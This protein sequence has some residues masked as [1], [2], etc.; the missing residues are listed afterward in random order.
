MAAE[1]TTSP[2]TAERAPEVAAPDAAADQIT[3][4]APED[5]WVVLIDSGWEPEDEQDQP[6]ES[7][8]VG[9]WYVEPD[10]STGTFRSNPSYLP[11][12]PDSPTDP[13]DASLRL[14]MRGQLPVEELL[15]TLPGSL[16][17]IGLD[18]QDVPIITRAPDGSPSVLV[19]SALAHAHRL[20]VPSWREVTAEGLADSLPE[21][22]VDVLLN[23]GAPASTRIGA[24]EFCAAVRRPVP[25]ERPATAAEPPER[26]A[27]P[28]TVA[29]LAG[30]AGRVV[31]EPVPATG[32][33]V[34]TVEDFAGQLRFGAAPS[35]GLHG[36]ADGEAAW[37]PA[38]PPA[39]DPENGSGGRARGDS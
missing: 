31:D 26:T 7:A 10:G 15:A 11:S 33:R 25:G 5:Q 27:A 28:D 29:P 1:E 4:E 23:P 14:V 22:G 24:A 21:Q 6:P 36:A 35:A 19:L 34:A 18:E 37:V 8:V 20:T 30:T 32:H 2:E 38:E 12:S 16:L 9:A 13:V 3:G 39:S 17:I